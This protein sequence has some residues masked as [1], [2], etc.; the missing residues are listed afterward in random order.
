MQVLA[1]NT[2]EK[3]T[4]LWKGKQVETGIFKKPVASICITKNGILQDS[5]CDLK[6]HGDSDKAVYAYSFSNYAY[7]AKHYP[8]TALDY[9]VFGENITID[10]M[11][12][13]EVAIGDVFQFGDAVLQ[14]AQP[15]FPC[16]KL[17][18]V[19][20]DQAVLKIF[21]NAPYP[22]FYFRVLQEGAVKKGD[23]ITYIKKVR[24][25][26]SVAEVFSIYS[27]NKGDKEL[28]KQILGLEFLAIDW[29]ERLIRKF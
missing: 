13:S 11:Q 4:V 3:Q 27:T 25:S 28:L 20:E 9:G 22:G 29:K 18:I 16:Y 10:A 17:G 12:E 14:V 19:F 21:L 8:D 24:N 23:M 5:V 2:S 6:N 7:F 15:R 1:V 26:L